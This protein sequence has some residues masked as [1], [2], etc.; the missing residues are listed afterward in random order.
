VGFVVTIYF[1]YQAQWIQSAFGNPTV[2]TTPRSANKSQSSGSLSNVQQTK[3]SA[4]W[5]EKYSPKSVSGL[6]VHKK[7]VEH[8]YH[9][10]TTS[11]TVNNF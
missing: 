3:N 4:P 2:S 6:A 11:V 10:M 9:W 5:A 7:K 8:V 1:L